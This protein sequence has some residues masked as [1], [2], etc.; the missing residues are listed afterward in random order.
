METKGF[1]GENRRW[2]AFTVVLIA[3]G[4]IALYTQGY[5]REEQA[6][7]SP[8]IYR[9]MELKMLFEG[10]EPKLVAYAPVARLSWL[11]TLVGDSVPKGNSIVLGFEEARMMAIDRNISASEALWGYSLEDFFGLSFDVAGTL[12]K[13]GSM[14]DMMHFVG[15]E[16]FDQL[17]AGQNIIIKLTGD[18]M[19]KFFYSINP[20]NGNW[21]HGITYLEKVE[22]QIK[23]VYAQKSY[24]DLKL[25]GIDFKLAV[26]KTYLPLVL[27][28]KE[29]AMMK[30]ERLFNGPG[31][32]I[33]NFFGKDV[34]IAG[35]LNPTNTSLDM[36]H[37]ITAD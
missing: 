23:P 18:R 3:A 29:A 17:P 35:I 34:Y 32:T 8:Q 9:E 19:P 4:A 21:P 7:I 26:N 27:G 6:R 14:I 11:P 10:L 37:Y 20:G 25:G 15:K 16:K 31:D 12:R 2:I 28:S 1:F 13:T 5:F 30:E 22:G 36:L 24:I 33:E